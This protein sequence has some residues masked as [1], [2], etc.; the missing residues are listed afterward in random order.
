M[1]NNSM[2]L[3]KMVSA[4][5]AGYFNG[6]KPF[7]QDANVLTIINYMFKKQCS[8]EEAATELEM[9]ENDVR[10][11][12]QNIIIYYEAMCEARN[13]ESFSRRGR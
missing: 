12:I 11:R 4:I 6:L 9:D 1:A 3:D 8:L 13:R 2:Y 10:E 5:H 7:C